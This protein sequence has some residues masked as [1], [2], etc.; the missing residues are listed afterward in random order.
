M[1]RKEAKTRSGR[2]NVRN[3]KGDYSGNVF[4]NENRSSKGERRRGR[5]RKRRRRRRR[6]KKI[7]GKKIKLRNR[8]SIG[9]ERK[10]AYSDAPKYRTSRD[11]QIL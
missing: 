9:E 4:Q 7:K 6:R 1:T 10:N 11:Q 5:G 3:K 8:R 2:W